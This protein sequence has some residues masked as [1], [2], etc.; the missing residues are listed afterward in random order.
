MRLQPRDD[1]QQPTPVGKEFQGAQRPLGQP[2]QQR[3][4]AFTCRVPQQ[5]K[6]A[7]ILLLADESQRLVECVDPDF[8]RHAVGT[9]HPVPEFPHD[10]PAPRQFAQVAAPG[11]HLIEVLGHFGRRGTLERQLLREQGSTRDQ[12]GQHLAPV[13]LLLQLGTHI[14]WPGPVHP[15]ALAFSAR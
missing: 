12:A 4:L 15:V 9:E 6:A 10:D 3:R 2:V 1:V 7:D 14:G 11:A 8:V 5:G 13:P